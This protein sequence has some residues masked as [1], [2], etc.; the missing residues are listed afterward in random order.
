MEFV[1]MNIVGPLLN[2]L[3]GH[4]LELIVTVH[5]SNLTR[6]VPTFKTAVSHFASLFMD[7]CTVL[8]GILEYF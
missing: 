8:Q 7:N 6:A 2:K 3:I 5:Y 4:Q 1:V